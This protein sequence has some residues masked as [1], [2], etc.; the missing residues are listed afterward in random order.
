MTQLLGVRVTQLKVK[1]TEQSVRLSLLN[2]MTSLGR[3]VKR[4]Y[5]KTVKTWDTKPAFSIKLHIPS[6]GQY[7]ELNVYTDS[8]IYRD[9]D[10]GKPRF[11]RVF[12]TSKQALKIPASYKPKTRKRVINSFQSKESGAYYIRA[13]STIHDIEAREFTE[14]LNQKYYG[15]LI[16]VVRVAMMKIGKEAF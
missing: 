7:V 3:D 13:H 1:M 9:I 11:K 12:P 6:H 16:S 14:V 2:A 15:A 10:Y 4:D 5:E 8:E